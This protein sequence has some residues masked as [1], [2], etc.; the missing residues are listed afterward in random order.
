L[1]RLLSNKKINDHFKDDFTGSSVFGT[2][3]KKSPINSL[4]NTGAE[5]TYQ[6]HSWCHSW[7]YYL[8]THT[9][10]TDK[11]TAQRHERWQ[12]TTKKSYLVSR[13]IDAGTGPRTRSMIAKCS[14]LS[15]VCQHDTDRHHTLHTTEYCT[16]QTDRHTVHWSWWFST[17]WLIEQGLTSDQTH[18]RSYR[19]WVFTSQMTQP[20]MEQ[21]QS[22]EEDRVLRMD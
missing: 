22:T 18:Y 17:D 15:W 8:Q 13:I 5:F 3:V 19:G 4:E 7:C 16:Y 1:S 9:H 10:K 2:S 6:S 20:T 14:R 21:C 11:W 12:Y